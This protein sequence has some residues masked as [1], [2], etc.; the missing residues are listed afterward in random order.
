MDQKLENITEPE[1]IQ[2]SERQISSDFIEN[3]TKQLEELQRSVLD[4]AAEIENLH[5]VALEQEKQF[6]AR[7]SSLESHVEELKSSLETAQKER[8]E[9]VNELKKIR[10]DAILGERLTALK[11][12]GLL[13]STE[14]AQIKQAERIKLMSDDEFE[15]YKAELLD[16]KGLEKS[17]ESDKKEE[18]VEEVVELIGNTV[19]ETSEDAKERIRQMLGSLTATDTTEEVLPVQEEEPKKESA[20]INVPDVK[21]L[22]EGFMKILSYKYE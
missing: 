5:D 10:E 6:E 11:D 13:R 19:E 18:T 12:L 17:N 16:I 20:S 3:A 21:K 14:E 1:K 2:T 4:K 7:V 15:D 9:A 22:T 8:D